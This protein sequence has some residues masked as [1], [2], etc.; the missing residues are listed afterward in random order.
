[1]YKINGFSYK[2]FS[3]VLVSCIMLVMPLVLK[4][5]SIEKTLGKTFSY[6][7]MLILQEGSCL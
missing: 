1:M 7:L 6:I 5:I 3:W 2:Y 4:T